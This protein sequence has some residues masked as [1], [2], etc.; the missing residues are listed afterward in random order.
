MNLGRTQ[1]SPYHGPSPDSGPGL[2]CSVP[3]PYVTVVTSGIAALTCPVIHVSWQAWAMKP[4]CQDSHRPSPL[5]WSIMGNH[6]ALWVRCH[7]FVSLLLK[8][9]LNKNENS[10]YCIHA[11]YRTLKEKF[12][13]IPLKV[14]PTSVHISSFS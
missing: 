7:I 3:L 12:S 11:L 2:C 9:F 14:W 10:V 13:F 5:P 4:V 6:K 8:I 1:R